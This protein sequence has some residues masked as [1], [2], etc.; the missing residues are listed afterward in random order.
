MFMPILAS[1][2]SGLD[3]EVFPSKTDYWYDISSQRE[4]DKLLLDSM[5][6]FLLHYP[7]MHW[8]F[9]TSATQH[10]CKWWQI[11]SAME[12]AGKIRQTERNYLHW[13]LAKTFK[14]ATE[15]WEKSCNKIWS[16]VTPGVLFLL[17]R[18]NFKSWRMAAAATRNLRI[19]ILTSGGC[20]L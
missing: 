19:V 5:Q 4:E 11:T 15:W 3:F 10:S 9:K 20:Y 17:G 13:N 16:Q 6:T 12:M 14:L 1:N 8:K 2:S 7:N 18:C